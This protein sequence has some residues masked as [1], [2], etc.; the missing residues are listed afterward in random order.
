M[1]AISDLLFAIVVLDNSHMKSQTNGTTPRLW[2]SL[3]A[4]KL[5]ATIATPLAVLFLGCLAWSAQRD[6]VQRWERDQVEQRKSIEAEV[7][8]REKIRDLRLSIY[9]RTAPLLRE[10]VAYHFHVGPWQDLTPP[11]V[12]AKKKRLDSELQPH[13]ALLT[14]EF[15]ALYH[16]FMR[17]AFASAGSSHGTSR[18]RSLS[19]C[20]PNIQSDLAAWSSYF[21]EEDRR[22]ELCAAYI[23]LLGRFSEELLLQSLKGVSPTDL[24]TACPPL[25]SRRDC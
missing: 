24:Q 2:N 17:E 10:V 8:E 3:E 22:K 16:A 19:R 4:C 20:R 14:P 12:I 21:T 13:R 15:Y 7:K 6:V 5:A 9:T 25:Y 1:I 11:D 23:G 18:I